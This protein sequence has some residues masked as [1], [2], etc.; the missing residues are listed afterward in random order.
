MRIIVTGGLGF[1]GSHASR[2]ALERGHHVTIVDDASGAVTDEVPGALVLRQPAEVLARPALRIGPVDAII[3]CA[4]PVGG[5]GVVHSGMV[6]ARIVSAT[7]A[8]IHAAREHGAALVNVSSSEVYGAPGAYTEDTPC[9]VPARHSPRLGYAL[10]KRAAENDVHTSGLEAC[11]TVRPFNVVGPAQSAAKGFVL[12][13]WC[14]QVREG[15]PLTIFGS[16][17]QARAFTSVHDVAPFLVHL[18]EQLVGRREDAGVMNVGNPRN[19][20]TIRALASL[21]NTAAGRPGDALRFTTGQAEYAEARYEEAEG[22]SKS[23]A[24]VERAQA[25]GWAPTW[26]LDGIVRDALRASSVPIPV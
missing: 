22:T 7:E 14:E 15:V 3:H 26:R 6:A 4:A 13:R 17:S 11:V 5:L 1:I 21:V 10:G 25:Y 2:C 16:G 24:N 19:Y 23:P 12:P 8:A 18:A 9:I 20:T